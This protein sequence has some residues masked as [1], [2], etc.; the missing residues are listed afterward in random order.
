MMD[1]RAREGVMTDTTDIRHRHGQFHEARARSPLPK[2]GWNAL[3]D[4]L[5][6]LVCSK[7][8]KGMDGYRRAV[9]GDGF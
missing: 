7:L 5:Y 1:A 3:L 4:L 9:D 2:K 6:L 8:Q